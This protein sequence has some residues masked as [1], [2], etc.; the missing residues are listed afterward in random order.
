MMDDAT[1]LRRYAETRS[2]AD[3]AEFVRRHLNFVYSAA[4]RQ[5]NGD[6]HLAQDIAQT[7]FTD[8]ARKARDLCRHP[9]LSGWLFTSTRFAA[10]KLVRSEQRRRTREQEAHL[11]QQTLQPDGSERL[12]WNR[13]RPVID[14]ALAELPERDREAVL[15]RYFEGHDY[16]AVGARLALSENAARMRVDRA[17]D[18]LRERLRLRGITS[19]SA[20][21]AAVLAGQAV[22]A[23]PAGLAASVTTAA[24]AAPAAASAVLTFM[25]MTKIQ[26]GLA[27]A[28]AVAGTGTYAWQEESGRA[29][30][31][32]IAALNR[33]SIALINLRDDNARLERGAEE[34]ARLRRDDAE[35]TRLLAE[36]DAVTERVRQKAS[37]AVEARLRTVASRP[38]GAGITDPAARPDRA[39]RPVAQKTPVYPFEL[40]RA[41]IGGE[42]AI[43][44]V[45]GTDGAVHDARIEHFTHEAFAAPALEALRQWRF[46]P[47]A[48]GGRLV[49]TRLTIPIVFQI[50]PDEVANDWF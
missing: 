45:V 10:A 36:A 15:L 17:V 30:R 24:L 35:M 11:M 16:P 40:R 34:A 50:G 48:K 23:A 31:E 7:V 27:A 29:L 18:K 25:S 22:A 32:E 8:L 9:V 12:D 14:E 41:G 13:T 38:T 1:L 43:S 26:L 5:V 19:T 37:A 33:E 47:G 4:L 39:P 42:V 21:L 46:D 6:T 2:E 28:V 20:A 3:F 44:F 49:N